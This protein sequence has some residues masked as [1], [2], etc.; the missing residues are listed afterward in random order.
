MPNR[1][2]Q[3]TM[4]PGMDSDSQTD[5][6]SEA[7]NP[8]EPTSIPNVA[9][10][11]VPEATPVASAIWQSVESEPAISE[12]FMDEATTQESRPTDMPLN[13][14]GQTVYVLDANSLI[15][16]V[17]HAIPEMTSPAGEPVNAVFGFTRDVLD[18]LQRKQPTYLF[19]AFD[20][21]G[22][23]FRHG[24]YNDYKVH[25][26]EMPDELRPQ[27]P[28]IQRVMTALG[29]PILSLE[30]F[31]ADD[32]LAAVAK[33]TEALGGECLLVTTDKD[34][35][36]LIT[37]RVKLYNIRKDQLYDAA[38]LAVDWGVRPDQVV[39]FQ[40][41]VGDP[42]DHVPGVPLIGPKIAKELLQ[43]YDT[44]DN[45]L[46]HAEEL[47]AGKR[48]Q[49]LIDGRQQALL[50]RELVRL[51]KDT[52]ITID[53]PAGRTGTFT[54]TRVLPLCAAFGFHRI[55][56]QLKSFKLPEAPTLP[57]AE[58][59][60]QSD[61]RTIDTLDALHALITQMSQ[62]KQ[63][64]VDT[65]TT[66]ISPTEAE[67]VGYSFAWKP[68]EGYYV[69]VRAPAGEKQ[70]DPAA[71]VAALKPL[72]ENPAVGKVG[73]NLKYDIIVLRNAGIE[74]AGVAYDT[75]LASYLL[76]AG[77]RNHNLD[78][79]AQRYL[80]HTNIKISELIGTGKQQK[81][82]D[83]VPVA[84]ITTYAAED[85]D[86][87]L[88]L[89]P[90]LE[91]RLSEMP[92]VRQ[93]LEEV[94]LPL[95]D[96][97]VEMECNGIRI[98]IDRLA[99]LSRQYGERQ[100]TLEGEIYEIAGHEFNIASLKQLQ[101]VLFEE[102]KLPVLSKTKTGA[103]TDAD[104]LEELARQ[105]PLPA[106][107]LQ[108]RQ[109]TKLKNTYVDALPHMVNPRTGRVHA[110]FQQ[111]VAATGRLSST[112]PNLQNIPIRTEEGREIRSAFL[113]GHEGWLLLAAD[114]SQIELRVLAHFSRDETLCTA[115]ACDED[116]HSLVASQVNGI[117]QSEVTR[118]MRRQ[119]K[120]VNFGVI[121]GQSAFGLAKSLNIEQSA[122]T[123]FIDAYFARYP[124]V[125]GFLTKTLEECQAKGYVNT[126]L[127]RRRAI[128]GIRADAGRQVS[129]KQRNLP[130]RTAINTVIQ[131]SAA[132]LIKLAM[133]AIHRRLRRE[134]L[135]AK[136]LLQI[137]DELVFEVPP[138]ELS[139]L[140]KLVA[141]EMSS[142]MKLVVPLK[143]D[144]K[145]GRNWSETEPW[146]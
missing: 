11:P 31:E 40:S 141:E 78:E 97:L 108:Y 142:V 64:S 17:F 124:G 144:V 106:K 9:P 50:S 10:I 109:Y 66:S 59:S 71:A 125:D 65:E 121:Y 21:P 101:K 20:L 96:V 3:Q 67:I 54:P 120:A 1:P 107:L 136:M 5:S 49:N 87:T 135:T 37:E 119:A 57:A 112:D 72:L 88:R 137:H 117:P 79:L 114:Y 81:R 44:L 95:I 91:A 131:G 62:Q 48:K 115:F 22:P 93:L 18:L 58:A 94:E 36:Q 26:A 69:P 25:R 70:I 74:V 7:P 39:D 133:I 34:C 126:I 13:L 83:E 85:A 61:Y 16:Q 45:L 53:W 103:S 128:R 75:M 89:M 84:A 14:A 138:D 33:Q 140:A 127:G 104:V 143:V 56:E 55:A 80:N 32:I 41:L 68:G 100:K 139:Y 73:Q 86:V 105:H 63:I 12:T 113:P 24:L 118:E 23:T 38:A 92:E 99:E 110:S 134:K 102:Q 98:D 30:T 122:A 15:F 116:I 77:E 43:K 28:A 29:V 111:A 6:A 129:G 2:R 35:R 27:I 19:C 90:P 8:I 42:V 130:E 47:P 82:M 132:D 76:D 51:D 146:T 46:A 145:T 60:W 123:K 4:L 52:P